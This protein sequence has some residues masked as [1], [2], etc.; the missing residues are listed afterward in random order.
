MATVLLPATADVTTCA[1]GCDP[2][3]PDRLDCPFCGQS[4]PCEAFEGPGAA[5]PTWCAGLAHTDCHTERCT[6][7]ECWVDTDAGWY[8]A[9]EG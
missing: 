5:E 9:R 4:V 2:S 6:T 7:R 1:E 8:A 3:C